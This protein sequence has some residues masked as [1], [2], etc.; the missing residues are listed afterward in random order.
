MHRIEIDQ[1]I[2]TELEKH[3][4]GFESPNDV[5]RRLLLGDDQPSATSKRMAPLQRGRLYPLIEAGIIKPGD[6]LRHEQVRKGLAFDAK[7]TESGGIKTIKE[8]YSAP[9]PALGDLVGSQID[10]WAN[11]NHVP[12]N[13]SLRQLR[14]EL[15]KRS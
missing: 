6:A 15:S 7:V 4:R 2:Y 11:W 8:I 1:D 14:K 10:G 3:V 9:S 5:L 13:K 12:T